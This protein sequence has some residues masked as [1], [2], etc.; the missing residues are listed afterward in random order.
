MKEN[1]HGITS[2]ATRWGLFATIA[3]IPLVFSPWNFDF[4]EFPKT[5]LLVVAA[6][7]LL[8]LWLLRFV[9]DNEVK[10]V[11]T[12][13]DLP[14]LL[15]LAVIII[16]TIL[17][18]SRY[19]SIVGIFGRQEGGLASWAAYAILF[20]VGVSTLRTAKDVSLAIGS[21]LVSTGIL[22][23][24]A[25]CYYFGLYI[26]P[27][28]PSKTAAFSPAGG[29]Y[30]LA[31]LA[32]MAIPVALGTLVYLRRPVQSAPQMLGTDGT[33]PVQP[34]K[35]TNIAPLMG[36]LLSVGIVLFAA[37]V[38]L[39]NLTAAWVTV[40]PALAVFFLWSKRGQLRTVSPFLL[41]L[42]VVVIGLFLVAHVPQIKQA[43]PA[44][45]QG[46]TK[47]PVLGAA[48]SWYIAVG[49]LRD[50]PFF[51]SGPATYLF[52]FTRYHSQLYNL[53]DTWTLRYVVAHDLYMQ[54]LTTLGLF[55]LLTYLLV[56]SRAAIFGFRKSLTTRDS[57]FYP[58]K[59]G[60]VAAMVGFLAGTLFAV[61]T[62]AVMVTFVAILVL[63]FAVEVVSR[64][65]LVS[66]RT[67]HF[68][69]TTPGQ[70]S[71][72]RPVNAIPILMLI[73]AVLL[74]V[75][76]YFYTTQ[77][78][79]ANLAY[80]KG[81]TALSSGANDAALK[82]LQYQSQAVIL[83]PLEDGYH[84]DLAR[85][86]FTVA[87]AISQKK[88]LNDTDKKA[89]TDL[90]QQ[91]I[92]QAQ[93]AAALSPLNVENWQV[94]ADIYR[95]IAGQVQGAGDVALQAFQRAILTDPANP[96]Q[97]LDVGGL[98]FAAN[99]YD[100]AIDAFKQAV[101]LKPNLANA[102]YNLA[103]AYVKKGEYNNA[104]Q[105]YQAVRTLLNQLPDSDPNKKQS[106]TTLEKEMNAIAD[107]VTTGSAQPNPSAQP[108]ASGAPAAS[109]TPVPATATPR[110]T[111][112]PRNVTPVPVPSSL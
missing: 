25:L 76:V 37:I 2:T 101:N 30:A 88:D 70:L 96:Q 39:Y 80:V 83:N 29:M 87:L 59:V 42:L 55:G 24:L 51:G 17:S 62:T 86:S 3:L 21:F 63:L 107:K 74:A 67:L 106:I 100:R 110:P 65:G 56:V 97:L 99:A 31:M 36:A 12:P 109:S 75:A 104:W 35:R 18:S 45:K 58:L 61:P 20:F 90:L 22:A 71:E 81:V 14:L 44:L 84:R 47:P 10:L 28:A 95:R 7:T 77:F 98:Y 108:A 23:F 103:N 105:A 54:V 32:A 93:A 89:V 60:L 112:N 6:V 49:A 68:V 57:E 111:V 1:L 52:D 94:L 79:R 72:N 34:V 53:A 40:I 43:I 50:L 16:S 38:I 102:Y 82:A 33:E 8:V 41:A 9:L 13:L 64:S 26:L 69:L 73:P 85:T 15:F 19:V 66:E 4:F 48:E 27:W 91:S 78:V 5:A 46:L 11:R 92:A